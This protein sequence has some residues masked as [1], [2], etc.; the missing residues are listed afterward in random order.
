MNGTEGYYVRKFNGAYFY[1]LQNIFNVKHQLILK[2]DWYDPN[3]DVEKL[4]IS[5][6]GG[7]TGA[8]VKYSTLGLGY[9]YYMNENVKALFWY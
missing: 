2:Y 4:Q 9:C 1:L 5:N 7:Y 3:T 8:D 6:T